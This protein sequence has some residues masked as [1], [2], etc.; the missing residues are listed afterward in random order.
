MHCPLLS[1]TIS[2]KNTLAGDKRRGGFA[3][4]G[5]RCGGGGS[6][7]P[8]RGLN[9]RR[10]V[11]GFTEAVDT[12]TACAVRILISWYPM[13][14]IHGLDQRRGRNMLASLLGT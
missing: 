7:G 12:V 6:L 13:H 14:F 2:N 10:R 4:R 1:I 3:A 8:G 11:W 5:C 9:C